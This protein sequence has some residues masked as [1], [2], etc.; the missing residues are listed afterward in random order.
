[1]GETSA[2]AVAVGH[3]VGGGEGR[4]RVLQEE[5]HQNQAAAL[6]SHGAEAEETR[7]VPGEVEAAAGHGAPLRRQRLPSA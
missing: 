1:M 7:V 6:P 3:A 5:V 2:A 4:V